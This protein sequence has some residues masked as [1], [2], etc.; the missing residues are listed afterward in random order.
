MIS[1]RYIQRLLLLVVG[2]LIF[3]GLVFPF[4]S[5]LPRSIALGSAMVSFADD[6][7][8]VFQNA[9]GLPWS[10]S[11]AFTAAITADTAQ[12]QEIVSFHS[13]ISE[14]GYGIGVQHTPDTW[15]AA[16]G[17]GFKINANLSVGTGILHR[18]ISQSTTSETTFL[19]SGM[20]RPVAT[21]SLGSQMAYTP[22]Q[23]KGVQYQVG[24]SWLVFLPWL[25]TTQIQGAAQSAPEFRAGTEWWIT[26]MFYVSSGIQN[27]RVSGGF[28]LKWLPFELDFACRPNLNQ[29]STDLSIAVGFRQLQPRATAVKQNPA[30]KNAIPKSRN[31][32]GMARPMPD[33]RDSEDEPGATRDSQNLTPEM[34]KQFNRMFH[35]LYG[36]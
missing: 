21:L 6:G 14:V 7:N 31:Y 16:L 35:G 36:E 22:D 29:A 3:P 34:K 4:D 10:R 5:Q 13:L 18:A 15:R 32:T 28:G 23:A 9:A 33:Q 12:Q 17:A 30:P 26:P 19:V 24:A 8:A 27:N 2:S 1:M 11:M 20:T 25:I